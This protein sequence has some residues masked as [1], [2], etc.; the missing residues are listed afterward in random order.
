[1]VANIKHSAVCFQQLHVYVSWIWL[2]FGIM[3]MRAVYAAAGHCII[4]LKAIE[5]WWGGTGYQANLVIKVAKLTSKT[6]QLLC[7]GEG[8]VALYIYAAPNP[9]IP[10]KLPVCLNQVDC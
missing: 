4:I 10:N 2:G 6:N 3:Q 5:S 9:F 1:M 7:S 8:I